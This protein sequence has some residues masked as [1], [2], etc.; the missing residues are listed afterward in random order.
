MCTVLGVEFFDSAFVLDLAFFF[1]FV[2]SFGAE[3]G[4]FADTVFEDGSEDAWVVFLSG[5]LIVGM[6]IFL[7]VK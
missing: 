7:L 2:F 4:F 1:A 6:L 3:T 5:V